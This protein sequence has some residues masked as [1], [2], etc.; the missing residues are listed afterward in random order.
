LQGTFA[1]APYA[2]LIKMRERDRDTLDKMHVPPHRRVR[3]VEHRFRNVLVVFRCPFGK[4]GK[5][6][7]AVDISSVIRASNDSFHVA[8][9]ERRYENASPAA[10]ERWTAILTVVFDTPHAAERLRKNP[11]GVFVHAIN[12][13]KE[14][15]GFRS[16]GYMLLMSRR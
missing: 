6:Q 10:T 14:L 1:R 12:W 9:T 4:V 3:K 2:A 7:L 15:M 13:S 16:L 8:S 5:I 11:L